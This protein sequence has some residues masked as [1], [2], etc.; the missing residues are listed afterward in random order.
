[1]NPERQMRR[2]WLLE[3]FQ[4]GRYDKGLGVAQQESTNLREKVSSLTKPPQ[5]SEHKLQ[6]A[7]LMCSLQKKLPDLHHLS[8]ENY[9]YPPVIIYPP[10]VLWKFT[11]LEILLLCKG[12]GLKFFFKKVNKQMG[13]ETHR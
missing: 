8:P 13:V 6:E 9:L 2:V 7:K 11:A 3:L 12:V 4:G 5:A 10:A 1:M